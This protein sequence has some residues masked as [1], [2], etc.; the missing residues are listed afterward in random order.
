[1]M[2]GMMPGMMG[3]MMPGMMGGMM[4][5]AYGPY[6]AGYGYGGYAGGYAGYPYYGAYGSY[7]PGPGWQNLPLNQPY[8][9]T[10]AVYPSKTGDP[11]YFD[12]GG[13]RAPDPIAANVA[14]A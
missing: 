2:G 1:M 4:P 10:G 7:G 5:G 8:P 13:V 11:Y 6:A 14:I 3:G 12:M 9:S